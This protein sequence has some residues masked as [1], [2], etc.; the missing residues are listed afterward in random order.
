MSLSTAG[1]Y[2]CAQEG[3]TALAMAAKN[4]HHVTVDVLLHA[5]AHVETRN[6]QKNTPLMT[7]AARGHVSTV[8]ALLAGR[9][10]MEAKGQHGLTAHGHAIAN[11]HSKV[12]TQLDNWAA[13]KAKTAAQ[14]GKQAGK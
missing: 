11:G 4:G 14:T 12:A 2:A 1:S 5:G 13:K 10:S 3:H 8:A 6:A 7:A 9:A